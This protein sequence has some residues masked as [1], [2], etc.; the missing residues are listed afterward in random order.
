[1]CVPGASLDGW[2]LK[3]RPDGKVDISLRQPAVRK[4]IAEGAETVLSALLKAG[5]VL[6]IGTP[7]VG[8]SF[9]YIRSLLTIVRTSGDK[10]S[11]DEISDALGM[12]K[13]NFKDAIGLLYRRR[14]VEVEEARCA[15]CRSRFLLY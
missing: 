13:K 7:I 6:A 12:S 2:I 8:L 4:R 10:S 9:L 1:V 11:P 5:N 3:V 15:N 14:L